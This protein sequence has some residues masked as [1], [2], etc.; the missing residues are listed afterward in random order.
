MRLRIVLL[1]EIGEAVRAAAGEEGLV[2]AGRV[3]PFQRCV[4]YLRE[5][6][7]AMRAQVV[8]CPVAQPVGGMRGDRVQFLPV[9]PGVAA[10]QVGNDVQVGHQG[11]ELG[12]GAQIELGAGIDVERLVQV[13]CL[14]A[15]QVAVGCGFVEREAVIYGGRVSAVE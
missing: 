4:E 14:Y 8:E 12:A 3:A 7:V 2:R 1:L 9:Q 5:P 13:V 15:Q 6:G 11:A 10:V